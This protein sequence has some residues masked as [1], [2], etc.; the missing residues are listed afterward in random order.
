[1]VRQTAETWAAETADVKVVKMVAQWVEQTV[2]QLVARSAG[3][4]AVKLADLMAVD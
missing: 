3:S 1:M 2:P 4:W